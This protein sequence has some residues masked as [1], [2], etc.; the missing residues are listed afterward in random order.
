MKLLKTKK[1]LALLAVLAVAA[2][3]AFGAYAYFTNTGTQTAASAVAVGGAA[4]GTF[5]IAIHTA[6]TSYAGEPCVNPGPPPVAQACALQPTPIG[7]T[8]AVVAT[9]PFTITNNSEA[10]E[11]VQGYTATLQVDPANPTCGIANFVVNGDTTTP[12]SDV[13]SV[14]GPTEPKGD[15]LAPASDAP[16]NAKNYSVTVEMIDTGV[17]QNQCIGAHPGLKIDAV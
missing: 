1:G 17:S 13:V 11:R 12:G 15:L 7:D 3:S 16:A 2:V 8:N 9:V 5:D 4:A 10:N 14:S 6:N